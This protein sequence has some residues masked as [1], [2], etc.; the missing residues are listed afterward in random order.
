MRL[1]SNPPTN[2]RMDRSSFVMDLETNVRMSPRPL[3]VKFMEDV[4]LLDGKTFQNPPNNNN[5]NDENSNGNENGNVTLVVK[6]LNAYADVY[7]SFRSIG[8]HA[9]VDQ[10]IGSKDWSFRQS[11]VWET[12]VCKPMGEWQT[13]QYPS[14]NSLHEIPN[15]N[16]N[17][18][19]DV[20]LLSNGWWRD[21]WEVVGP[22]GDKTVMKTM[23]YMHHFEERNYDRHR[24]DAMASERLTGSPHVVDVYGFCGNSGVYEFGSGGDASD[25][26]Y[27]K[28]SKAYTYLQALEIAVEVAQGIKSVHTYFSDESR[29]VIMENG[30]VSKV[31]SSIAHTDITSG[32]F[33]LINGKYKLNDFNRCRFILWNESSKAPCTYTVG[34]NPGKLRSPEEYAYAPQTEKVDVYSMGVIF[35]ELLEKKWPFEELDE[36]VAQKKTM[37]GERSEFSK[38]TLHNADLNPAAAALVKAVKMCWR[39]NWNDRASAEEIFNFLSIELEKIKDTKGDTG[40]KDN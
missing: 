20:R 10:P 19:G 17:Q 31:Y 33:I 24:R 3:V 38:N 36:K 32:Q 25:F 29:G 39:Q 34:N 12:D 37:S 15:G 8:R 6:P 30:S 28:K 16:L 26:I 9:I 27:K 2:I 4:S 22:L 7:K 21:V 13:R 11:D 18:A 5:L 23:R 1:E 35:Y 40:K 14:C